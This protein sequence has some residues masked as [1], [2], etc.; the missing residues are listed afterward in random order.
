MRR[1]VLVGLA[2]LLGACGVEGPPEPVSGGVRIEG[3]TIR[4]VGGI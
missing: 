3:P 2:L 4:V 1:A